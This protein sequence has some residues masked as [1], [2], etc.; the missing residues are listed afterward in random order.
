[1]S[2]YID[3][4]P[5]ID[6]SIAVFPGDTEFSRHVN[7]EI[8][9]NCP[10]LLSHIKSTVHLGAHADAPN[11]YDP[12]GSDIADRSLEYYMGPCQVISAIKNTPNAIITMA[13]LS[14]IKI[15]A[16]RILFRTD[17]FLNPYKWHDDFS[18]ICPTVISFLAEQEACLIGIDTPSID[19]ATSKTLDAHQKI[20]LHDMAIL[21]GLV[22]TDVQDG[23][24]DL[25]ALPLKIK[26]ADASPV[27][28]ILQ[29]ING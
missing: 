29:E 24:Y 28:A 17:S 8:S 4:S 22:L 7:S 1:M 9:D 23:L 25:I 14:G 13:D 11:H 27:R 5:T 20:K 3:I 21:E 19:H 15:E 26:G 18:G 10:V 6:E 12:Q 2:N 16:P